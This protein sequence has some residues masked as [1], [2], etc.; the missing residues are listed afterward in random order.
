MVV[1]VSF[2]FSTKGFSTGLS[3]APAPGDNDRSEGGSKLE[4]VVRESSLAR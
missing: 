3:E 2:C 1:R 4:Y